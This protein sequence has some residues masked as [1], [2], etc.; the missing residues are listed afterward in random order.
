MTMR[1]LKIV[2]V[3]AMLVGLSACEK[4]SPRPSADPELYI[5]VMIRE[6]GDADC[7]ARRNAAT[8]L[9]LKGPLAERALPALFCLE[10]DEDCAVRE[11]ARVAISLISPRLAMGGGGR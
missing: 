9:G 3:L 5:D 4:P 10:N 8:T 1:I 11:A 2:P 7:T 6:L